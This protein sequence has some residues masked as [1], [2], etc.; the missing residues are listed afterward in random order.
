MV[1][2]TWKKIKFLFLKRKGN[3]IETNRLIL[4]K[5]TEDDV[6]SIFEYC[7]NPNIGPNAGWKPHE[8]KEETIQIIKTVFNPMPY[9]FG[10]TLKGNNDIIGTI[11]LIRDDKYPNKEIYM[12]GYSLSEN[13]WGK[14]YTTEA[15]RELLKFGFKKLGHPFFTAYCYPE[16]VRSRKVLL[17]CGFQYQCLLDKCE[18]RFD[19]KVVDEEFYKIMHI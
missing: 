16:N 18:E 6:D 4:R 10:I 12:L 11:G 8:N 9:V 3:I 7:K 14:G 13:H 1:T 2:H 5:I 17:K 19:G 15:G